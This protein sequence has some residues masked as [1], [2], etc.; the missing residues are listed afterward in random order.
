LHV[1]MLERDLRDDKVNSPRAIIVDIDETLLDNSPHSAKCI[2]NQT[3]YPDYWEEWC[4]LAIAKPLP[5]A[6]EFLNLPATMAF[7]FIISPTAVSILK[8]QPCAICANWDFR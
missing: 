2:E 3:S 7:P 5:G 1:L 4:E 6:V 8:R